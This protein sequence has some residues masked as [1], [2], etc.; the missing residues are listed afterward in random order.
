VT[1]RTPT[2]QAMGMRNTTLPLLILVAACGGTV[3]QRTGDASPASSVTATAPTGSTPVDPP[4]TPPIPPQPRG[5][6]TG[7]VGTTDVSILYPLP[8]GGT[9][10]VSAS[11][12]GN[13]GELLSAT[14]FSAATKAIGGTSLDRTTTPTRSNY[15]ALRIVGI[16]FEPLSQRVPGQKLPE[17]RLIL[18]GVYTPDPVQGRAQPSEAADG[19]LHAI[20]ELPNRA[21]FDAMME[22]VLTLKKAN[23]DL[24][25]QELTVHP[26]LKAQGLAGAFATGLRNIVLSHVGESR[27]KRITFF[28][29]NMDPDSDAWTFGQAEKVGA[30]WS[31]LQIPLANADEQTVISAG[32]RDPSAP[33]TIGFISKP[34][35]T[36]VELLVGSARSAATDAARRLAYDNALKI[37]NPQTFHAETMD[38]GNCHMAESARKIGESEFGFSPSIAAFTHTRSLA[39]VDERKGTNNL[40]AFGYFGREIS[41]MQ[42]TAN[43]SVL[44]A[45]EVERAFKPAKI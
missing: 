27:L 38:C 31:T 16:R 39:R 10:L 1:E 13:H 5:P 18:Q 40:H 23:G 7:A 9:D 8:E 4:S 15:A 29:H 35:P 25:L 14:A 20:Y 3:E 22:E 17:V 44:V 34:N 24:A 42:R 30:T 43:E 12:V 45:E 11:S 37:Q 28:D 2:H 19:A 26:I 41:I 33:L 36:G 32:F 6:Y 21:E